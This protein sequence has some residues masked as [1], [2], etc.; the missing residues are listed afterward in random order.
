MLLL[1]TM[2]CASTDSASSRSEW[3]KQAKTVF[4]EY[5]ML[6]FGEE[7]TSKQREE[8][9]ML[10]YYEEVIKTSKPV[11]RI[12]RKTKELSVTDLPKF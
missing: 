7:V 12:N 9:E 5:V 4:D 1:I 11:I 2:G 8:A 3:D 6:M 10:K